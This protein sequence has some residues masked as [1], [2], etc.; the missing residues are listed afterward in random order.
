MVFHQHHILNMHRKH[1]Y[2]LGK[3][4][5]ANKTP[6]FVDMLTN[7]K[8]DVQGSKSVLVLLNNQLIKYGMHLLR[9]IQLFRRSRDSLL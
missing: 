5:N 8:T 4:N 6:V 9:A 3:I 7:T 2:L 1:V